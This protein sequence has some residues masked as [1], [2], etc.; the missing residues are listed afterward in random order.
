MCSRLYGSPF[1]QN[2]GRSF[3]HTYKRWWAALAQTESFGDASADVSSTP[4][5]DLAGP[6]QRVQLGMLAAVLDGEGLGRVAELAALAVGAPVVI[7]AP[8][9]GGC[10]AAP[11]AAVSDAKRGALERYV[12]RGLLGREAQA[13]AGI[14][15]EVPITAANEALG[16]VLLLDTVA[17]VQPAIWELMRFAALATVTQ[18]AILKARLEG[19]QRVRRSLLEELRDKGEID[20]EELLRKAARLGASLQEGAVAL[21]AEVDQGQARQTLSLV[22]SE[23]PE[24]LA[25]YLSAHGPDAPR[26]LYVLIPATGAE[27]AADT[28]ALA[29]RLAVRI[30]RHGLVGISSFCPEPAELGRAVQEAELML[31]VLLKSDSEA[32]IAQAMPSM[33]TYRL[34]FRVLVSRPAEIEAFLDETI[35]PLLA[36]DEQYKTDLLSTLKTYLANNCSMNATAEALLAHRHT[37]AYRLDRIQELTGLDPRQAEHREQLGLGLKAH[38]ILQSRPRW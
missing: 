5:T 23:C 35:A 19:E 34:L 31:D 26:R 2:A 24:A 11:V 9:A 25:E 1:V 36:Y 15:A 20:G 12:A 4:A 38:R 17:S 13:P 28:R 32:P 3:I 21:C 29:R 30:G 18:H 10:W 14:A 6:E 22:S 27:L 8:Q 7:V 33:G 16:A 37:V